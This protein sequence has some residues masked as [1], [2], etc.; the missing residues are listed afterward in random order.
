MKKFYQIDE[1]F[2]AEGDERF[3]FSAESPLDEVTYNIFTADDFTDAA[4][5]DYG[6]R[7]FLCPETST[8]LT[9]FH[10]RF[11][12]WKSQRGADIAAAFGALRALYN[13]IQNYDST[14]HKTGTETA[15]KT[16]DDW[17]T[18]TERT[19][20]LTRTE[21]QT[22]TGWA[23]TT[24]DS[25]TN[26]H[27]KTTETPGLNRG[28]TETESFA[29][30]HETETK[31]PTDW[32]ETETKAPTNW[33]E[34]ETKTPTNWKDTEV[35]T[36]T[37]W[38]ETTEGLL[39][40]NHSESTN[41]IYAFNSS[42][43]VDTGKVTADSKNKSTVKRTGTFQTEMTHSGTFETETETSGTF[44]TETKTSGTFETDLEKSGTK[45]VTKTETGTLETDMTI[46]GTK[47]STEVQSGTF[48]T[49]TTD[50]GT[51]TTMTEQT[52]TFEDK[53]TYN[54][55]VTK[56]G[57]IGVTTSQQMI[58]SE[59]DLRTRRFVRDVIREFFDLVSV[60]C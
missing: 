7:K 3:S 9:S 23:K 41:S 31:T 60:Y 34:T 22:P 53:M 5:Y 48:E 57:N 35:Q 12:R 26:Y 16:P 6:E 46:Q 29:N 25:A 59:I 28:T 36:P 32:K 4:I 42:T 27:E 49:E 21:T 40:D 14:E 44:E 33:K 47:E 55:T 15:L 19:P 30:Y 1:F 51:D 10:A 54:T 43:A 13:P 24:T 45:T 56:S 17:I 38:E 52:G 20:D 39:A 8:P 37:N 11:S 58:Q 50:T 2:P 18:T